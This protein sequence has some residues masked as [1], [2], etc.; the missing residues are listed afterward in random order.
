M[1]EQKSVEETG[2][3]PSGAGPKGHSPDQGSVALTS[4]AC[5]YYNPSLLSLL[6][7]PGWQQG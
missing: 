6:H 2:R 7:I 5:I 1:G 3:G 4:M